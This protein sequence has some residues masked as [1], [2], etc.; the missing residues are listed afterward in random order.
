[1]L[2][3]I[4]RTILGLYQKEYN[5]DWDRVLNELLDGVEAGTSKV[6]TEAHSVVIEGFE[7]WVSNKWYSYGYLWFKDVKYVSSSLRFRPKFST[8]KRLDKLVSSMKKQELDLKSK[9]LYG[10]LK[11]NSKN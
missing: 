7:I 2:G 5:E 11:V 9:Q 3:H 10:N 6:H 4:F 8:M 1:M